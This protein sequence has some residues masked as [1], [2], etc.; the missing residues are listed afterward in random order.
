M[1]RQVPAQRL[2]ALFI[3][4]ATKV[5]RASKSGHRLSDL[6]RWPI[7]IGRRVKPQPFVVHKEIVLGK[8]KRSFVPT[9][10]IK[11]ASG[12][13][14]GSEFAHLRPSADNRI[15][16]LPIAILYML[17]S[18]G[19]ALTT[20]N[21]NGIMPATNAKKPIIAWALYDW[22]NSAFA[23]TVMAAFFPG[24]FQILLECR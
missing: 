7:R 1:R 20:G 2:G 24:V 18:K 5:P 4:V 11:D 6:G 9:L 23:T 15:N 3:V 22:A 12:N 21:R 8:D 14:W 19:L 16:E 17:P 10:S 13:Y